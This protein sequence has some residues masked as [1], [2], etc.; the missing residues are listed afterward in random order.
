M[1]V[2]QAK[3]FEAATQNSITSLHHLLIDDPL[4]LDRALVNCFNE[5]PLHVAAMLG[6]DDFVQEIV[7]LKPE[8]VN[9]LSSQLSS[10]LHLAA[11]KGHLGVVKALLRVDSQAC[12]GRDRNDL[13]PLHLAAAKGRVEAVKLLLEARPDTV[14][15]P[16]CGGESILHLCV[17]SYQLEALRLIL[18]SVI[19]VMSN[20]DEFINS[21]DSDGNTVLHLA[22]ADKQVE[23]IKFLL[24]VGALEVNAQNHEGLTALEVLIRSRRDVRDSQIEKLLKNEQPLQKNQKSNSW[25]SLMEKHGGWLDRKKSTLMVVASLIATM[26]FQI[27]V[28]PPGGAWQ[29]DSP[30]GN[31]ETYMAG[32]SVLMTTFPQCYVRFYIINTTAFIAS[33]SI[34]L[35]LMSG[36]P[37]RRRLFVWILM[38]ITWIA[39]TAI[40]LTYL[41]AIRLMT[42]SYFENTPVFKA[43]VATIFVWIGLMAL[44]LVAHTIRM[45][46]KFVT[47]ARERGMI[48]PTSSAAG[49]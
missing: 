13:L 9:E 11:A 34:I 44:L 49:P 25:E 27:G 4:I 48:G 26:A 19:S 41:I 16:A 21:T 37:M 38:V 36:L 32:E 17:K 12:L 31:L 40:A 35:L 7:G 1:E 24:S 5:T 30:P 43:V 46:K 23:T 8:L 28:N 6:H 3:L 10:P 15:L 14:R 47:K 33:L 29:N 20:I 45:I 22:V 39:I 2:L 42:P 18:K